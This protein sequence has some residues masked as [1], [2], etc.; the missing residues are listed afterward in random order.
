MIKPALKRAFSIR[1]NFKRP[2]FSGHGV[3]VQHTMSEDSCML[4]IGTRGHWCGIMA[5]LPLV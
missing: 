3:G 2:H 1:V 4:W 5:V